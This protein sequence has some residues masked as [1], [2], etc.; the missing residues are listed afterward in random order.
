MERRILE[1]V[2]VLDISQVLA[3]PLCGRHLADLGADVIRIDRPPRAGSSEPV[4]ASGARALLG[5]WVRRGA[6]VGSVVP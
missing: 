6:S 5:P 2:R 1:G 3:G 4:R